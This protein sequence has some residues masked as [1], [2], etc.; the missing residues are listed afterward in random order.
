MI[1]SCVYFPHRTMPSL[2]CLGVLTH[3][4][5]TRSGS[6]LNKCWLVQVVSSRLNPLRALHRA[7]TCFPI[8]REDATKGRWQDTEGLGEDSGHKRGAARIRL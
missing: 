3:G 2:G 5:V 8:V 7:N 6:M 1:C 4:V